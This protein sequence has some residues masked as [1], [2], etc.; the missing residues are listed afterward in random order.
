MHDRVTCAR[1]RKSSLRQPAWRRDGAIEPVFLIDRLVEQGRSTDRLGRAEQ[2]V[3]AGLQCKMDGGQDVPLQ[4]R[5]QVDE[6]IATGDEVD[7]RKWGV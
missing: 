7:A 4:H 6:H 5:S 2:E 3:A 1:G